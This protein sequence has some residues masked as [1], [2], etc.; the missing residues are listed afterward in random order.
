[1][2]ALGITLG[3][4][5]FW[6]LLVCSK[7]LNVLLADAVYVTSWIHSLKSKHCQAQL[8]GLCCPALQRNQICLKCQQCRNRRCN[9]TESFL[10][11][12][13]NLSAIWSDAAVLPWRGFL[14]HFIICK[15]RQMGLREFNMICVYG[16]GIYV[17]LPCFF[18]FV[19]L[20]LG[21]P[22]LPPPPFFSFVLKRWEAQE[23]PELIHK[24]PTVNRIQWYLPVF[25][26][27]TFTNRPHLCLCLFMVYTQRGY[28]WMRMHWKNFK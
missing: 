23:S 15:D 1:M 22:P 13:C 14:M 19:W 25:V 3:R 24:P 20:G 2:D 7:T 9:K 27:I 4:Y 26:L 16:G 10:E 21:F 11:S 6:V 12:F 5:P 18:L 8:C 28:V 17:N